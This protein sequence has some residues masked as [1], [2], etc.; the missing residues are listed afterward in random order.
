MK[1]VKLM[2]LGIAVM[3]WGVAFVAANT[4][5]TFSAATYIG[6]GIMLVGFVILL[7]GFRKRRDD[8]K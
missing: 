6:A 3:L 8:D 5:D 4:M 7:I 1:S 2:L